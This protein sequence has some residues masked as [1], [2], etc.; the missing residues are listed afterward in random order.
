MPSHG[1]INI[2]HE[3]IEALKWPVMTMDF[4]TSQ[5]VDLTKLEEGAAIRFTLMPHSDGSYMITAISPQSA[6]GEQ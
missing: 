2:T 4:T 5:S 3:P 1:M 6:E